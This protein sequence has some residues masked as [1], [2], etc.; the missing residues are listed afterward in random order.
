MDTEEKIKMLDTVISYLFKESS[1][2]VASAIYGYN[3]IAR[4]QEDKAKCRIIEKELID[5]KLVKGSGGNLT[6]DGFLMLRL[7]PKGEELVLNKTSVAEIYN[8]AH[9]KQEQ[10]D[11]INTLT[12]EKLEYEKEVRKLE[13]QLKLTNLLKNY[14][15]II[16]ATFGLGVAIA[17]FF[18][19]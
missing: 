14:W 3:K 2:T 13:R 15:Y 1:S 7:T 9:N 19:S 12:L 16:T 18:W 8:K 4:T 6:L 11:R 17:K 10:E 5:L